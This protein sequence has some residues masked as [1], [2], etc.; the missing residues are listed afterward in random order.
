MNGLVKMKVAIVFL[1]VLAFCYAE[2][3]GTEKI[4]HSSKLVSK[5]PIL[6]PKKFS[7]NLDFSKEILA[8]CQVLS[9]T[10]W[11]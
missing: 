6:C 11:K 2:T 9:Q 4:I 7:S 5:Y 8:L 10:I 1:G 3:Y